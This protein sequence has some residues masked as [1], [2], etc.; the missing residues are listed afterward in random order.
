MK[1]LMDCFGREVR[2]TDERLAHILEHAEMADMATEIE[3][4]LREPQLVRRSRT[5]DA[6]RLYYEFYAQTT[7][8][9]QMAVHCGQIP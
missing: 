9:W 6:V 8:G 4:V 3:R 2:L 1:V 7:C 5:D